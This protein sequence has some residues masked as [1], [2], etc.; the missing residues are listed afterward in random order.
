MK[1]SLQNCIKSTFITLA[2]SLIATLWII[3]LFEITIK[4]LSGMTVSNVIMAIGYRL[5]TDLGSVLLIAILLYPLY[6]IF[7]YFEK[8]IA[9]MAIHV[10]FSLLV[11]VQFAMAKYNLSTLV[12]FSV[13]LFGFS[14]KD[15]FSNVNVIDSP[16]IFYFIPFMFFPIFFLLIEKFLFKLSIK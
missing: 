6:F 11:I 2:I 1:K 14:F 10:I 13:D 5:L 7:G 16:S 15:M 12:N 3:S 8:T 4:L 9:Q